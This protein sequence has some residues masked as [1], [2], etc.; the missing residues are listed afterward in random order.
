MAIPPSEYQNRPWRAMTGRVPRRPGRTAR[1]ARASQREGSPGGPAGGN[2]AKNLPA[3]V[4]RNINIKMSEKCS[5]S[6]KR[7]NK[8]SEKIA[9]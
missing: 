6:D 1:Q 7:I 8:I 3:T 9:F 5:N 4:N 2:K